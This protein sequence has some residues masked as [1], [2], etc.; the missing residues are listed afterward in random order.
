MS[1]MADWPVATDTLIFDG[2][3]AHNPGDRVPPS[4]VER[5]GWQDSV[6]KANT[7][8]AEK[9]IAEAPKGEAAQS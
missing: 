6:A 4:N 3:I 1:E 9:A 2:V 7:K 8:A 5:N